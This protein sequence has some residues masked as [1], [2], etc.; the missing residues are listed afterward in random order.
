R[1]VALEYMQSMR[2]MHAQL[3]RPSGERDGTIQRLTIESGHVTRRTKTIRSQHEIT[4]GDAFVRAKVC[5]VLECGRFK[6]G[7]RSFES[8]F[9][10]TVPEVPTLSHKVFGLWHLQPI[11]DLGSM[12]NPGTEFLQK[13]LHLTD[14]DVNRVPRYDDSTPCFSDHLLIVNELLTILNEG[15]KDSASLRA[16]SELDTV[17]QHTPGG[18]IN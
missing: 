8:F 5:A 15:F 9:G 2:A 17:A 4:G 6:A 18:H 13:L 14:S 7:K 10:S 12:R 1:K 11:T 3:R 16:K